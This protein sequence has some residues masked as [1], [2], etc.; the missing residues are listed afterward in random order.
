[1]EN[2]FQIYIHWIIKTKNE[3]QLVATALVEP[4]A[5]ATFAFTSVKASLFLE[6]AA[7]FAVRSD[8]L[9]EQEEKASTTSS[10]NFLH[11]EKAAVHALSP[12]A[13][14]E[15]SEILQLLTA[16]ETDE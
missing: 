14:S 1:M 7:A 10:S 3:A 16:S 12:F 11:F 9:F 4:V 13:T 6:S 15:T 2:Y 8:T 5:L